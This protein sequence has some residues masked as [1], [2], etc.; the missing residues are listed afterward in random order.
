MTVLVGDFVHNSFYL[1]CYEASSSAIRYMFRWSFFFYGLALMYAAAQIT[2]MQTQL[3]IRLAN[4]KPDEQ[5]HSDS[6]NTTEQS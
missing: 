6:A 3:P 1:L 5:T 2:C 4:G